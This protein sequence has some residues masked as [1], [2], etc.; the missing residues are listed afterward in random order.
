MLSAD[1]AVYTRVKGILTLFWLYVMFGA[2]IIVF[3]VCCMKN[4][5]FWCVGTGVA[6]VT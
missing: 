1:I 6:T 5:L 3:N 4:C 2:S